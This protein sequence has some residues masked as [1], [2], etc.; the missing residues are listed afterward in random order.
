M[1]AILT[2]FPSCL[3]E[4]VAIARSISRCG[5]LMSSA[6]IA[7]GS[8]SVKVIDDLNAEIERSSKSEAPDVWTANCKWIDCNGT[9]VIIL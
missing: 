9:E 5:C 3:R 1:M 8:V 4:K 7:V 6:S 2:L